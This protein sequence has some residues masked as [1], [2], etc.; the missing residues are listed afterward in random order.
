[1]A[2]EAPTAKEVVIPAQWE[3]RT[4]WARIFNAR[5][6]ANEAQTWAT[7]RCPEFAEELAKIEAALADLGV[8]VKAAEMAKNS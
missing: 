1:M 2:A 7:H 4:L 8:R 6:K 3:L 5:H